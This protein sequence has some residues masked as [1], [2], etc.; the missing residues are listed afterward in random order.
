MIFASDF[1]YAAK[2]INLEGIF[3]ACFM[4]SWVTAWVLSKMHQKDDRDEAF[5]G[6]GII[7]EVTESVEAE[8]AAQVEMA[9]VEAVQTEP[10]QVESTSVEINQMEPLQTEPTPF[11]LT[12]VEPTSVELDQVGPA[13]TEPELGAQPEAEPW[14]P[15][16]E[17]A[18]TQ[19]GLPPELG[20]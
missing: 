3:S 19:Q 17:E 14:A 11:G 12:R 4:I 9:Q 10:L 1:K 2:I 5:G 20:F 15:T 6:R 8:P 18:D 16:Q 7:K 13:P